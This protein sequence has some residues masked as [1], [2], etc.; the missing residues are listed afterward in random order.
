[1]FKPNKE[2]Q[3]SPSKKA[4][5]AASK[6]D[7]KLEGK[8]EP[9]TD[10]R[11]ETKPEA[12]PDPKSLKRTAKPTPATEAPKTEEERFT[13]ARKTASED[14]KVL[15]LRNK[16]DASVSNG[17]AARFTRA[18]LRAM[19]GKMRALEPSLKDRIDM[20]EAAALRLVPE[21]D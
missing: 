3:S 7:A 15:E 17:D 21:V 16:A 12:K 14:P 19:Y 4:A 18:Y 1:M 9:K 13:L 8:A 11:I 6:P 20:T 2:S 10:P 5:P